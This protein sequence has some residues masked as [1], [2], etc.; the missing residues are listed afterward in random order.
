MIMR[1]IR[2]EA[3]VRGLSGSYP[4]YQYRK[5]YSKRYETLLDSCCDLGGCVV[6]VIPR[7]HT[8]HR[9][10]V[11]APLYDVGEDGLSL[12]AEP[13]RAERNVAAEMIAS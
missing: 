1:F 4:V 2:Q 3:A 8:V 10:H 9:G 6:E 5:N 13:L 11:R 12:K 7:F